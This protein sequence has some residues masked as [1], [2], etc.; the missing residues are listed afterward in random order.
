MRLLCSWDFLGKNTGVSCH[1]LFQ[2]IFLTQEL[3]LSLLHCRQI[4]YHWATWEAPKGFYCLF[5]ACKPWFP[6]TKMK[7]GDT[8]YAYFICSHQLD[9]FSVSS[10]QSSE[11]LI[12]VQKKKINQDYP[13]VKFSLA[14][15]W[16]PGAKTHSAQ[17]FPQH[18]FGRRLFTTH[19]ITY[20][21]PIEFKNSD[22]LY[23]KWSAKSD[24]QYVWCFFTYTHDRAKTILQE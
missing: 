8:R 21:P 3:N 7:N 19:P 9:T 14:K 2:G 24:Q 13:G 11:Q 12:F 22:W 15:T 16:K 17:Y 5:S 6:S 20:I 10:L 23:P 4:L 18:E 1:F